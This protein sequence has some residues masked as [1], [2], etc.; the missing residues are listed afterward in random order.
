MFVLANTGSELI[1]GED[2]DAVCDFV[3][4]YIGYFLFDDLHIDEN[5]NGLKT[6]AIHLFNLDG[7]YIPLSVFLRAAY[8][9]FTNLPEKVKD[10]VNVSYNSK[11]EY[12]K[13]TDGLQEEDW[14]KLYQYRMTHSSL[15]IHFFGDFVSF[16][17]ANV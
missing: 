17:K 2:A 1:G 13:Q 12:K 4:T 16:I 10:Y 7:I 14:T 6:Q 5:F 3:A 11:L 9:A 15:D 8:H